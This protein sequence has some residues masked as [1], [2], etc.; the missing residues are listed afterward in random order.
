MI[1]NTT[2]Q[3]NARPPI[4][5]PTIAPVSREA[6]ADA[7]GSGC[8]GDRVD[9]DDAMDLDGRLKVGR[10][11]IHDGV[12]DAVVADRVGREEAAACVDEEV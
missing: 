12:D 5:P 3:T 7:G 4:T 10:E 6:G 8:E 9:I 1:A 2:K 11:G